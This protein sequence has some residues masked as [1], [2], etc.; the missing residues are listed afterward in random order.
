L[1][2]DNEARD[3][4]RA[5]ERLGKT[6]QDG[7]IE[8]LTSLQVLPPGTKHLVVDE[9]DKPKAW[10]PFQSENVSSAGSPSVTGAH[11]ATCPAVVPDPITANHRAT[12]RTRQ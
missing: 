7:L 2:H 12:T 4:R 1:A 11:D 5:F 8:F 9:H 10:P 3:Q 6:D